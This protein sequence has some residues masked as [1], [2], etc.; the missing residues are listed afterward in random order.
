MKARKKEED[1]ERLREFEAKDM[2]RR[3]EEETE[4]KIH[5]KVL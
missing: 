2:G 3:E 4:R 5:S 1:A